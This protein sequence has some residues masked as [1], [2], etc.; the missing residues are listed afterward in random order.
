MKLSVKPIALSL[1]AA[2]LLSACAATPG[3]GNYVEDKTY[4]ITIL[5][6]NDHHGR[7]WPNSDGEYGLAAQKTLVDQVRA[8]VKA[9][10]GYML[11]L[12]GGD[13][14]TGVPESDLQDAEPDFR[15][16]SRIGYDAMAVGNHEF[17]KPVPVLMKQRQ[18]INFPMLSANIYQDGKRMF[19]P[20]AMFNLGGVKVVVLGLTT[21]DTAK[22]VNPEQV[23]GIEFRSPIAEAGKLVP[24]LRQKADIVIAATHMGHYTDGQH[25]VNAPGDVEMARAVKGLDLIVGGHSQNPVCMKAENQRDDAYVPGAPCA[26][27]RQNGAWIVQAHEWGKY[28]GRADFEFRNGKLK[29][30]KYQLMP[31]NLKK[32][33]KGVDGKE[34]KVP[35]TQLI[36]EDGKLRNF[37]Q[38]FQNKGQ[39]ALDVP[40]G[41]TSA[42][43]DGDRGVVRSQ[44]TNLGVFVGKVMMDKVKADFAVSNSGGI[45]DSLPA[46]AINYRDV[47][48]VFPFGSTLAYVDLNGQEA[49]DYL[50]AAASMTPGAGAFG[51]FAGVKLRIVGGQLQQALIG[52]QPIDPSKTYRM[53][54]NSFIAAG[55]DG[56]PVMNKHPGYVNTG[57]VDAEMLREYIAAHSPIDA[58]AYSPGDAVTRN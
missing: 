19:D 55:G 58:A 16:M 50:K 43:L 36:E 8:E 13:I 51:Q 17:D 21:D 27:D 2:G 3:K 48:K 11:L 39:A 6:T 15:G 33:V 35:Y 32:S 4:K 42:K 40:V 20:Y 22:M 1:L 57:F 28:V 25:G 7:F 38:N 12:S 52:G 45:R 18:W 10:G 14:N 41:R 24:E 49:L 23:K 47:L 44:P 34:Q 9:D 46:G 29:L 56:Y 30:S 26:P 5:H 37:L 31:V 54:I 53:A